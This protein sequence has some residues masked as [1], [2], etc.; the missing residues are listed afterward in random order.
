MLKI[1]I[2]KFYQIFLKKFYINADTI[3]LYKYKITMIIINL[4]II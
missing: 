3:I 2:K 1:T 4:M